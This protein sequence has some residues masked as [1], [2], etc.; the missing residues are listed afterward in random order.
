MKGNL[1]VLSG[2]S[3]AGK[4]TVVA[5]AMQKRSDMCFSISVT[6]RSP[7]PN[8]IDG[9]DYYFINQDR[10][11]EMV[12]N[13]ELLEH[14]VYVSNS[15]GTPRVYVEEQIKAGM[16][17]ILDIEVQGASQVHAN[18]PGAI[19]IFLVPP[20]LKELERR[21]RARGTETDQTIDARLARA[22]QE[23]ASAEVYDYIIVN[24]DP[25]TAADELIA[26]LTA[27]SCRFKVR[28]EYL[29]I[30]E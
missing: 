8:E 3:G 1:I 10:F 12:Q 22:R 21:L 18:A 24:D 5:K 26:I 16:N 28:K 30:D 29:T 11:D 17:V 2:P 4:S 27:E 20:S 19:M 6:T 9:K 14:A 23:Y 25:D 13:G 15:Y 7:R